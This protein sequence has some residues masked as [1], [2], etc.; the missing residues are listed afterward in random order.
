MG[1]G[2]WRVWTLSN[3]DKFEVIWSEAPESIIHSWLGKET[4][5][6]EARLLVKLAELVIEGDRRS[7]S[8]L[9]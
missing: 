6:Q 3:D 1:H 5:W 8:R 9:H 7:K 2:W 4:V